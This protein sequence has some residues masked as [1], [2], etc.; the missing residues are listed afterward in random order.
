[1]ADHHGVNPHDLR[2]S[3]DKE[4]F[5]L[6]STNESVD[7]NLKT[8][9]DGLHGLWAGDRH[10]E[11][12]YKHKAGNFDT[13]LQVVANHHGVNPHDLRKSYDK[14]VFPM[15]EDLAMPLL[16]G[17]IAKNKTYDEDSEIDMVRGE[18]KAIANKA[19]HILMAMPSDMHIAPW[20]QAKIAQA[21][22]M[23]NGVHD[24]MVYGKEDFLRGVA[25]KILNDFAKN[26]FPYLDEEAK[27]KMMAVNTMLLRK[28]TELACDDLAQMRWQ[29]SQPEEADNIDV[30]PLTADDLQGELLEVSDNPF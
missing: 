29:E 16:G 27:K 17:D 10:D 5:P 1:V 14:E 4:V 12:T 11:R 19:M 28:F 15:K 22:E 3:Y 18:L 23:I 7:N 30:G 6:K 2:K 25:A 20:V 9:T 26:P 8:A 21:K 24:H 13:A